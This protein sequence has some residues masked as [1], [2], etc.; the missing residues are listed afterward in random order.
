[1]V[2][3]VIQVNGKVRSK[4]QVPADID[5]EKLKQA[6]LE[7]EKIKSWIA[8]KTVKKCIVIPNKLVNIVV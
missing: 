8:A 3:Q 1:M 7:D 6:V 5:E 4:V 2:G